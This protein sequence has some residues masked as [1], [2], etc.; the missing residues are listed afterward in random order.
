MRS[1]YY[2]KVSVLV[3]MLQGKALFLQ[4]ELYKNILIIMRYKFTLFIY[5]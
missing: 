1:G 3:F 4:C 5:K 2:V